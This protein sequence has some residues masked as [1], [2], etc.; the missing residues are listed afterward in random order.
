MIISIDAEKAFEKIQQPFLIKTLQS[1]SIE[2]NY[3]NMIKATYDKSTANIILSDEKLISH[4]KSIMLL[5]IKRRKVYDHLIKCKRNFN[6]IYHA[7]VMKTH[8]FRNRSILLS[9]ENL[10][11]SIQ[12]RLD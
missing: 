3:L 10:N 12:K 11:I 1:V 2:G 7:F 6:D 9:H 4:L 5:T 8:Q